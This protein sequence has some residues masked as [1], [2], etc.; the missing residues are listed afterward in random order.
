MTKYQVIFCAHRVIL[1][2]LLLTSPL[3]AD[4]VVGRDAINT[5]ENNLHNYTKVENNINLVQLFKILSK[6]SSKAVVRAST[7][8]CIEIQNAITQLIKNTTAQIVN[9]TL[10]SAQDACHSL[11]EQSK[12]FLWEYKWRITG[13]TILGLYSYLAYQSIALRIYF[14][15]HERWFN[16]NEFLSIDALCARSQDELGADLVKEI[17]R[18]Y[19]SISAPTDFITPLIHFLQ[20]IE[21]EEKALDLYLQ[22]GSYIERL[23]ICTITG[24]NSQLG[25]KCEIWRRRVGYL[26]ATFMRWMADYKLKQNAATRSII[27]ERF[28]ILQ[29][30]A[31]RSLA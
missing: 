11:K 2:L 23:R 31:R 16:W 5:N 26:R 18:R 25:Q 24:Y 17:Q 19:T 12:L 29:F 7:N 28:G 8:I 20:E 13:L 21:T 15:A 9:N 30:I 27:D 6:I 3:F 14:S 1:I 4:N 10:Q 22:L